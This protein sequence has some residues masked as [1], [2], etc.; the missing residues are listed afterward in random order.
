MKILID[1]NN[2]ITAYAINNQELENGIECSDF[3]AGK[4]TEWNHFQNHYRAYKYVP[5]EAPDENYSLTDEDI[6]SQFIYDAD[7]DEALFHDQREE[8]RRKRKVYCF[9]I[10][11]RGPIWFNS[12]PEAK[13]QQVRVWYQAWLDA[14]ETLII[15]NN[16]YWLT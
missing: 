3:P 9:K 2:Y 7:Y 4:E 14:P 15:P 13:Q 1:E 12:L 5:I 6:M 10:I 8:I 11:N 16:P